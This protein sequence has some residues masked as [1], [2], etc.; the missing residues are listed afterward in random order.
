M[1]QKA[2]LL[3]FE[4]ARS[5]SSI[6]AWGSAAVLLDG[7]LI[8]TETRS[9]VPWSDVEKHRLLE[10]G[11]IT[12]FERALSLDEWDGE[13]ELSV[14]SLSNDPLAK[15]VTLDTG[16][17]GGLLKAH[18]LKDQRIY[19]FDGLDSVRRCGVSLSTQIA[20]LLGEDRKTFGA[21]RLIDAGLS[22]NPS[23]PAINAFSV[24]LASDKPFAE[25][26]A[27]GHLSDPYDLQ[28]FELLLKAFTVA[29]SR[30]FSPR[31][32]KSAD[33]VIKMKG[34]IVP[35][36][37]GLST[38]HLATV[39][40]SINEI[41]PVAS[42]IVA[43][44]FPFLPQPPSPNMSEAIAA[45][46]EFHFSAALS[47]DTF[48]QRVSRFCA[49]TY[50]DRII[51]GNIDAPDIEKPVSFL[52]E[53]SPETRVQLK[54][55]GEKRLIDAP[56]PAARFGAAEWKRSKEF[57]LLGYQSGL[58]RD[59]DKIE[60]SVAPKWLIQMPSSN[61]GDR[62]RPI[63]I[64]SIIDRNDFL[65]HPTL[66]TVV[67]EDEPSH[68]SRF[69]L[70][71]IRPLGVGDQG[72]VTA[73]PSSTVKE[74]YCLNLRWSVQRVRNNVLTIDGHDIVG[75]AAHSATS[76]RQ[77]ISALYRFYRELELSAEWRRTKYL[78][79]ARP[80]HTSALIRLMVSLSALGGDAP[81]SELVSEIDRRYLVA[82]RINNTRREVLRNDDLLEFHGQHNKRV[83][84]TDRG[85]RFARLVEL[86]GGDVGSE[87]GEVDEP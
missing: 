3:G 66:Y 54:R 51:S 61:N 12:L 45:S 72:V 10:E 50:I 2:T 85:K 35:R 39:A 75:V 31:G 71:N 21:N 76:A 62:V 57:T 15:R 24:L 22:L 23:D 8:N 20:T 28:R 87:S 46:A 5:A 34:G 60:V 25:E 27:R 79:P 43:S 58:I 65:F 52:R 55:L 82:V 1:T 26:L 56:P 84:L 18:H 4:G 13:S 53:P 74:S 86:A 78:K 16:K 59:G 19:V 77:W 17:V 69:F 36:E 9:W 49:L 14:L 37:G 7:R 29:S 42:S 32:D 83:R 73:L 11:A 38:E 33:Y 48:L 70:R 81:V 40:G 68:S 41:Q 6:V 64:E 30:S 63:G 80:G 67:R 47:G 44:H